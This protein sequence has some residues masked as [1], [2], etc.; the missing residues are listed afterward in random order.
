MEQGGLDDR[1]FLDLWGG[2]GGDWAGCV[3]M[4]ATV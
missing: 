1:S 4:L 2:Y 3:I